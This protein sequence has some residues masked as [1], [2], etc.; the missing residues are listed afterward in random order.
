MRLLYSYQ[1]RV[2]YFLMQHSYSG[3]SLFSFNIPFHVLLPRCSLSKYSWES[4][5]TLHVFHE[6]QFSILITTFCTGRGWNL[7]VVLR[8]RCNISHNAMVVQFFLSMF[9]MK[10]CFPKIGVFVSYLPPTYFAI[11]WKKTFCICNMSHF[12]LKYYRWLLVFFAYKIN[13]SCVN[14]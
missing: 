13:L 4:L 8:E 11:L 6:I 10:S 3:C 14:L 5:W 7:V 12:L 9:F 1:Y 2:N